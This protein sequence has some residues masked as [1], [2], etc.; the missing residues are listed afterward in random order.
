[1]PGNLCA[2]NAAPSRRGPG[3]CPR[4]G[5]RPRRLAGLSG[6]VAAWR[7][8]LASSRSTGI[9]PSNLDRRSRALCHAV[10]PP[11]SV[12][13]VAVTTLR[14]KGAFA[15]LGKLRGKK[16]RVPQ[17]STLMPKSSRAQKSP[18]ARSVLSDVRNIR[19]PTFSLTIGMIRHGPTSS[20]FPLRELWLPTHACLPQLP[21]RVWNHFSYLLLEPPRREFGSCGPT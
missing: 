20:W 19:P 4:R 6:C 12:H 2:Q 21:G 13:A 16:F 14:S 17:K 1:M 18:Q 8:T 10:L 11:R 3:P 5:L 7:L 9:S 15:G